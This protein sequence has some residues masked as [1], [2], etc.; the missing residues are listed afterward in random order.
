MIAECVLN[1]AQAPGLRA[2]LE[3]RLLDHSL[4]VGIAWAEHHPVLAKSD[5]PPVAIGLTC[6]MVSVR[7][8]SP[9]QTAKFAHNSCQFSAASRCMFHCDHL[10]L[11]TRIA[12]HSSAAMLQNK[13]ALIIAS[14]A[15]PLSREVLKGG[16]LER[17]RS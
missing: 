14:C 5:C 9:C 12:G 16:G 15:R 4:I 2:D 3:A 11:L 7:M 6:R 8:M 13:G 10:P 1:E 17:G